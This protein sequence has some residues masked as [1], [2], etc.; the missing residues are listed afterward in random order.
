MIQR[1]QTIFIVLST[2]IIGLLFSLPIAEIS[3]AGEV[4]IFKAQG[5]TL[6]TEVIFDGLP[7]MIFLGIILLL[8]IIAILIYKKR[9]RQ[10]RVL[11][12]SIILLLGLFGIFYYF[13]YA[14]FENETIAFK[15]SVA[16]PLVA[17]ILDYLAIR[18]IGKDEALVRSLDRIR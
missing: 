14:S 8:H 9:I 12:Y 16:F 6:G 13:T 15:I 11:T 17:I 1:I 4:Y 5:V 10:M 3:A 2:V 18:S 7:I